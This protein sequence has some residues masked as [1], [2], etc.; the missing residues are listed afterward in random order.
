MNFRRKINN[1]S[2]GF[3]MAPMVDVMFLLLIFFMVA[4][5]LAEAEKNLKIQVPTA[6]SAAEHKR[7]PGE[8]IVNIDKKGIISVNNSERS[9][10]QLSEI[11]KEIAAVY[12]NQPV[13]LRVDKE[14]PHKHFVKVFDLCKTYGISNVKI[15][16]VE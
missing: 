12:Q 3:Q 1:D 15:A 11:L 4:A 16:S 8:I 9:A 13:I 5:F 2:M 6:Q 14:A 7:Y 10:D